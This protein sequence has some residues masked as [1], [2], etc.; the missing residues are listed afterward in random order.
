MTLDATDPRVWP[1]RSLYLPQHWPDTVRNSPLTLWGSNLHQ[2]A[3]LHRKNKHPALEENSD[4]RKSGDLPK[5][6]YK[7][8]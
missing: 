3:K 6:K 8:Y 7:M 2:N 5:V 1:R 4:C